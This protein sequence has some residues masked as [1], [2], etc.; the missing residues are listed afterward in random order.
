MIPFLWSLCLLVPAIWVW[1]AGCLFWIATDRAFV[2]P[3]VVGTFVIH[4][5]IAALPFAALALGATTTK[6]RTPP[7]RHRS[8]FLA[9]S[10]A[11]LATTSA[12][13]AW[14]HYE[15][16][17]YWATKYKSGANIGLGLVMCASP[18]LVGVAMLL[19]G[20]AWRALRSGSA[21]TAAVSAA[22]HDAGRDQ[23]ERQH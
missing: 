20:T 18:L 3:Q 4:S 2:I 7:L 22:E 13:W 10:L 21:P 12:L 17:V 14:V 6:D 5:V 8:F 1:A 15:G 19:A 9:A 23:E 11:G 16:Y